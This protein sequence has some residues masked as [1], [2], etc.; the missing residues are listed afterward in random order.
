MYP[1][2]IDAAETNHGNWATRGVILYNLQRLPS[3]AA[4]WQALRVRTR[5]SGRGDPHDESTARRTRASAPDESLPRTEWGNLG[6]EMTDNATSHITRT[7]LRV[8]TWRPHPGTAAGHWHA[9]PALDEP[10]LGRVGPSGSEATGW[11]HY[12]GAREVIPERSWGRRHTVTSRCLQRSAS[13]GGVHLDSQETAGSRTTADDRPQ[14]PAAIIPCP[15][16][17]PGRRHRPGTSPRKVIP[18]R[19]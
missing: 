6:R 4:V 19:Q 3:A 8:L 18:L 9:P 10:G 11:H 12:D 13:G 16:D 1:S 5:E 15:S 17:Q 2:E 14:F 7:I